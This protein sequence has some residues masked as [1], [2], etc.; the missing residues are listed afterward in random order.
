MTNEEAI[1]TAVRDYYEGWYDADTERMERALHPELVKRS[2]KLSRV[3]TKDL[4]VGMTGDGEGREDGKD[5]TIDIR[6]DDVAS[7]MASATVR[8]PVYHEY[9]HLLRTDDGWQIVGALWQY[10]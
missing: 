7:S 5:R 4:M 6:I 3:L 8:T 9:L 2:V 10:A 1:T